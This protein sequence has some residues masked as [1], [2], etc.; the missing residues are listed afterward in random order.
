MREQSEVELAAE[1]SGTNVHAFDVLFG[2]ALGADRELAQALVG[3]GFDRGRPQERYPS[4]VWG[5]C[6]DL[7]RERL[8]PERSREAGMHALGLL[9]GEALTKHPIGVA[10]AGIQVTPEA[11]L[12]C[13]PRY[14]RKMR[15]DTELQVVHTGRRCWRLELRGP[16]PNPHFTTGVLEARLRERA[17][18]A[19]AEV[20]LEEPER[21]RI[22]VSW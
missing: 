7:A 18:P 21:Y 2:I 11:Y 3:C 10:Y 16:H 19:R 12:A 17:C 8:F 13:F 20:V 9:F 1:A 22:D 6:L 15:P 4:E 14:L 5:R